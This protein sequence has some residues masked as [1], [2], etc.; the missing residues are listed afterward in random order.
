MKDQITVLIK[1][2]PKE[3]DSDDVRF[4]VNGEKKGFGFRPKGKKKICL[5]KCPMCD[6]EN[7]VMN[8]SVGICTWCGFQANKI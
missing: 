5:V 3:N 4:I 6:E 1:E 2:T 8:V 7:Y